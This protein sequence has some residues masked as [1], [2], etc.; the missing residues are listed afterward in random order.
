[1]WCGVAVLVR[2]DSVCVIAI[3][4]QRDSWHLCVCVC[5]YVVWCSSSGQMG[6]SMCYSNSGTEGFL[7]FVCVCLCVCGVV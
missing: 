5:V 1:M 2:W 6:F 7:A 4:V 3:L